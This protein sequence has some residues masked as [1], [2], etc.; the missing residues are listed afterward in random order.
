MIRRAGVLAGSILFLMA[1]A[2]S[3]QET[4]Q[5]V[6]IQGAGFFTRGTSGNGTTYNATQTGSFL[7]T[8]RSPEPLDFRRGSVRL[9][10]EHR[11]ISLSFL[12]FLPHSV[13]HSSIHRK[14]G[15]ES[16]FIAEIK[17]EPVRPG[18]RRRTPV[19][20]CE[21][22]IQ[23]AIRRAIT[24]SRSFRLRS[25]PELCDSQRYFSTSGVPRPGV[26]NA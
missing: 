13:W 22:S 24:K 10:D 7:G 8:Y 17:A 14:P 23:L 6:S 9:R 2:V 26:Q 4:R 11:K 15:R 1:M 5:E 3:A 25:R 18:W 20:A 21:Q 16:S 19:C 12:K